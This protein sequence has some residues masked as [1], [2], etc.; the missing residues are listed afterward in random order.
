MRDRRD[1]IGEFGI[2]E[3]TASGRVSGFRD[4]EWVDIKE[5]IGIEN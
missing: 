1:I 3:T 4:D 5:R 2:A